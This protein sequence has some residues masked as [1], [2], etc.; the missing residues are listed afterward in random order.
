MDIWERIYKN[1]RFIGLL[2]IIFSLLLLVSFFILYSF[3]L[4]LLFALL[5]GLLFAIDGS[6]VAV[7]AERNLERSRKLLEELKEKYGWK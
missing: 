1:G 6:A 3:E 4:S 7:V 5:L 2:F